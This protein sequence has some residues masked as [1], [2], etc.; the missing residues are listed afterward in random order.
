M[1][2]ATTLTTVLS[3]AGIEVTVNIVATTAITL[4]HQVTLVRK[5]R[6]ISHCVDLRIAVQGVD[7]SRSAAK[8]VL[9]VTIRWV[10]LQLAINPNGN[11]ANLSSSHTKNF[12]HMYICRY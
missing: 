1:I 10:V 7:G 8:K 11:I 12:V 6:V 5:A 9:G 4:G 3:I 2:C